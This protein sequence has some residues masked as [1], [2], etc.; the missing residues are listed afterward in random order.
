VGLFKEIKKKIIGRAKK[1]V[2]KGIKMIA[3]IP[4]IIVDITKGKKPEDAAKDVVKAR[5]EVLKEVHGIAGDI[6]QELNKVIGKIT[7]K[8]VGE[9]ARKV[10]EDFRRIAKPVDSRTAESYLSALS[11]F[12]DTGDLAYINPLIGIIAGEIR[13]AR[14][15]YWDR[16]GSVSN[17]VVNLMPLEI[18][19]FA[20]NAKY[21]DVSDISTLSLPAIATNH[22]NKVKAVV[23]IDLIFFGGVP[24]EQGDR[25]L[26]LWA[27][28]LFH[29]KQY[30]DY[31]I[32]D[33]T[34]RYIGEEIGQAVGNKK[35]N[36][37]EIEADK[38]ACGAF[39]IS[40]PAYLKGPCP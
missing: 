31:G 7:E 36:A 30:S 4:S 32:E 11:N 13:T 39:R 12:V 17:K 40:N 34:K 29:V 26:H 8:V 14:D 1:I 24:A 22:L 38:F 28:E 19:A 21:I 25:A 9:G 37:L 16:A 33:F 18:Q 35:G 15:Q 27:H 23:A 20:K 3:P 10:V 2:K 5:I 6:E